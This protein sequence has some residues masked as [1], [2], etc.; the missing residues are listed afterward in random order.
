M[1]VN[2]AANKHLSK[3]LSGEVRMKEAE[4]A[5]VRKF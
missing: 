3:L 1:L 4:A 2:A 5:V